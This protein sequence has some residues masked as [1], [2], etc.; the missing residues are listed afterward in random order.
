MPGREGN[1]PLGN[2]GGGNSGS[3]G[4]F[5]GNFGRSGS[6][7]S[8]GG[9][10]LGGLGNF[11]GGALG[12]LGGSLLGGLF[13]GGGGGG[14]RPG[15]CGCSLPLLIIVGIVILV[16]VVLIFGGIGKAVSGIGGL[17]GGNNSNAGIID[18]SGNNGSLNG[19]GSSNN[20]SVSGG[21]SGGGLANQPASVQTQTAIDLQ[22]LHGAL[23][24]RIPQWKSSIGANQ[25]KQ[26]SASEAG[27]GNDNNIQNV[28]Y[29]SCG[30][31][32][33]VFVIDKGTPNNGG[34]ATASG[35]AYTDATSPATCHP[36]EYQV[37]DSE[38][39]GGNYWFVYVK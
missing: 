28:I 12:G 21:G 26:V 31:N 4:G 34:G 17:L 32:F 35:Y 15:G 1:G 24:S 13:G 9:G 30:S 25:E 6:A 38:N 29:G 5:G 10:G 8:R 11:G 23:D 22:E 33:Y 39:D 27:M 20:G 3:S 19:G 2:E 14:R 36:T 18:N 7:G 16:I 37:T